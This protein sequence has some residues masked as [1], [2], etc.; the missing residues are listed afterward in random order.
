MEILNEYVDALKKEL[1][2]N[3]EPKPG[4]DEVGSFR[5]ELEPGMRKKFDQMSVAMKQHASEIPMVPKKEFDDLMKKYVIKEVE[6]L[7]LLST[8]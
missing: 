4:A 5:D 6:C 3:E 1:K 7:G 2:I 8:K